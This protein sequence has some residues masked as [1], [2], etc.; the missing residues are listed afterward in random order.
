MNTNN[1][2]KRLADA[3][4]RNTTGTEAPAEMPFGF[5]TRVLAQLRPQRQLTAELLGRLAFDA[6]P[7]AAVVLVACWLTV[8]PEPPVKLA[9]MDPVTLAD[10]VFAEETEEP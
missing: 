9:A 2:W 8:R 3:A 10:V 5:D 1:P 7:V 4:S 6:V